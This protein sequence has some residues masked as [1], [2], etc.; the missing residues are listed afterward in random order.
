M[1][2][3]VITFTAAQAL[4]WIGLGFVIVMLSIAL[5]FL[6]AWIADHMEGRR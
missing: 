5:A 6:V 1:D 3:G 2:W 4:A